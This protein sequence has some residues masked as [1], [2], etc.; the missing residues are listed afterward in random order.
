[1]T[2]GTQIWRHLGRIRQQGAASHVTMALRH[3]W[4]LR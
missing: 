3:R 1:M 4:W 2:A